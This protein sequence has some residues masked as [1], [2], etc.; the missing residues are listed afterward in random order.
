MGD[1]ARWT[2]LER[3]FHAALELEPDQR[4]KYV[5]SA[6]GDDN[7]LRQRVQ[8]LLVRDDSSS[9]EDTEPWLAASGPSI[10]PYRVLSKLGAGGMGEVYLALDSRLGRRVALKVLTPQFAADAD[11]KRRFE[12]EARAAS[13]LNHPNIVAVYDFSSDGKL[14]YLVMEYVPG[15][16]LDRL[17]PREGLKLRE[18][19]GY[20]VQIAD[21]MACAHAAGIVHRDLKPANV[22]ITET[23]T[24]KVLDFGLAKLTAGTSR[25]AQTSNGM[26]VGTVAYMS[27]EQATG[28][29]VDERSDIFSFGS[30]L[31]EL[32]TGRRPFQ[33]DSTDATL[34]AVVN[35][36]PPSADKIAADVP[37]AMAAIIERCMRKD[38][39]ERF[40]SAVELKS[41]LTVI[42]DRPA[43][44]HRPT[45]EALNRVRTMATWASFVATAAVAVF[46][47]W[48][49]SSHRQPDSSSAASPSVVP[50]TTYPFDEY[51]PAFS[52]DGSKVAFAWQGPK[53]DNVDLY[54]KV[55]GEEE[56]VRLT[57]DPLVDIAPAWSPDG[58]WIAFLRHLTPARSP[59]QFG[60][61]EKSAVLV[62][63]STGGPERTIG[64]IIDSPVSMCSLISWD[65][66]SRWLVVPDTVTPGDKRSL[67]LLSPGDGERRRLTFPAPDSEADDDPSFSP[68]GRSIA[69]TRARNEFAQDVYVL[70]LSSELTPLGDP[71]RLTFDGRTTGAPVW[72]ADGRSVVYSSG[73]SHNPRLWR[74]RFPQSGERPQA[75]ELLGFAG[76]GARNPAI[77]RHGRLAF[78]SAAWD[79]D[80]QRLE[81]TGSPQDPRAPN[82][83]ATVIGSSRLDHTPQQ[84]PDGRIAFGSDRSGSH[85]IWVCDRDGSN[86]QQ[87][88]SFGGPYTADPFWSP[89]G[90]WIA[91]SSRPQGRQAAYVV[92]PG[93]GAPKRLTGAG[94]DGLVCGWSRDGKWIYLSRPINGLT[95]A[96]RIWKVSPNGGAPMPVT[97][98]TGDGRAIE[99]PDGRF[100]FYLL[101]S[102]PTA[103]LWRMRLPA[104]EPEKILDAVFGLNFAV[105]DTGVFFIASANQASIQFLRF[106]D[107][108]VV[109][110]AHLGRS[111][112]AYGMSL[113]P[114]GRSLLFP[115]FIDH[116]VDLML[117]ENFR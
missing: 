16:P 110:V 86:A 35:H 44:V 37:P 22:V 102:N 11:R 98:S 87:I 56:P 27:P 54:M 115:V 82:P 38:P 65:A 74:V 17:I 90:H 2:V 15:K 39:R 113:A 50:L 92:R 18:A 45:P 80:I 111:M 60:V 108:R 46:F 105:T 73:S 83:P 104:G 103:P 14:D 41:A 4:P 114:D 72:M 84:S 9:L 99:S 25:S 57:K 48:G 49:N 28:G 7:D 78:M 96:S 88:T 63:P 67:Y 51:T 91:F 1:E 81:L 93:A 71:V 13:A 55:V 26:I 117:V 85:E 47:W 34:A 79:A 10:G 20:A 40:G 95:G 64:E 76:Y 21:A 61:N 116:P 62:I 70:H 36:D 3:I 75:P 58:R 109:T 69:F 43:A 89:D 24:A 94:I 12:R 59:V 32:T 68:D 107:R 101:D 42:Q 112:P 31:Y 97:Q 33:R 100:L 5:R 8:S 53:G 66:S 29:E 19:L 77:S 106:A 30:L 52:P 23:G 6:C